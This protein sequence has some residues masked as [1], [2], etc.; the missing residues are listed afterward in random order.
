MSVKEKHKAVEC[1]HTRGKAT[2]RPG[3]ERS[4]GNNQESL[5]QRDLEQNGGLN[6]L[7]PASLLIQT[8]HWSNFSPKI[9][10][11]SPSG[12]DDCFPVVLA[13]TGLDSIIFKREC[14]AIKE[15]QYC[16][17]SRRQAGDA[18]R[19]HSLGPRQRPLSVKHGLMSSAK[20]GSGGSRV[21]I[22]IDLCATQ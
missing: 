2:P 6:L 3:S 21:R 18:R 20:P 1:L 12:I 8:Q 5:M 9:R 19:R 10:F 11:F 16:S 4:L 13:L 14:A 7:K 15:N 17:N 22:N